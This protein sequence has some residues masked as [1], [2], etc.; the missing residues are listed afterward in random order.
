M[1][2]GDQMLVP[3]GIGCA[4]IQEHSNDPN[5]KHPTLTLM[6]PED[7]EVLDAGQSSQVAF[8]H[9]ASS[10]SVYNKAVKELYELLKAYY[11]GT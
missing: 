8:K 2:Q 3:L 6:Y 7:T 1:K 11:E 9:P 4:K 5:I 10:F